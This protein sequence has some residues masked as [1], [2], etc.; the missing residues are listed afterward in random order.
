MA[1]WPRASAGGHLDKP[2]PRAGP[3]RGRGV[4]HDAQ[5]PHVQYG[6]YHERFCRRPHALHA[7]RSHATATLAPLGARARRC[8]HAS[9]REHARADGRARA[10]MALGRLHDGGWTCSPVVIS[11]QSEEGVYKGRGLPVAFQHAP[12]RMQ[13]CVF[14]GGVCEAS[15]F[16]YGRAGRSQQTA[17]RGHQLAPPPGPA[18]QCQWNPASMAS[19]GYLSSAQVIY[20]TARAEASAGA[21]CGADVR[22][23]CPSRADERTSRSL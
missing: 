16:R 17:S 19:C 13:T 11:L 4:A 6:P 1:P 2:H 15:R 14:G 9:T 21:S 10:S 12:M 18:R 8:A 23:P 7:S 5:P 3:S 22:R 20:E